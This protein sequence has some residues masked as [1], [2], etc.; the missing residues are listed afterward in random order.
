MKINNNI[1]TYKYQQQILFLKNLVTF[2][3]IKFKKLCLLY[4]RL[5]FIKNRIIVFKDFKYKIRFITL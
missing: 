2:N 3:F 5:K 4:L 1:C